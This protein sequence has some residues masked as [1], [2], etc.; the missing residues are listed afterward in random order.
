MFFLKYGLFVFMLILLSVVF[1]EPSLY[2]ALFFQDVISDVAANF[3]FSYHMV[4][5]FVIPGIA[6]DNSTEIGRI[7]KLR[8]EGRDVGSTGGDAGYDNL[9]TPCLGQNTV[10]RSA[11][12]T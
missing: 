1:Q 9:Q 7:L 5:H 12:A 4:F 8:Y 2:V 3:K 10:L 11:V 6:G